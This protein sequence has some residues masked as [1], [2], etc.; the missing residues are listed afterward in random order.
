MRISDWSSDV[1]SSDL[2]VPAVALLPDPVGYILKVHRPFRPAEAGG[3]FHRTGI[4]HA[5]EHR[6]RVPDL[7]IRVLSGVAF[8]RIELGMIGFVREIKKERPVRVDAV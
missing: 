4:G 6:R 7:K 3:F 1:C 5:Q 2:P 8:R